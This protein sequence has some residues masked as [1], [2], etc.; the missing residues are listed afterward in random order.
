MDLSTMRAKL[1]RGEYPNVSRFW[2]DFKLMIKNCFTFNPPGTDV[3]KCAEQLQV[4][5]DEKWK[6]MPPLREVS[7][8]DDDSEEDSDND[9][10]SEYSA[11]SVVSLVS[12]DAQQEP[13]P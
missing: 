9:Q 7:D 1:D 11:S 8:D 13:L 5:F 10:A 3:Y 6:Q 12:I 2:D 4:W